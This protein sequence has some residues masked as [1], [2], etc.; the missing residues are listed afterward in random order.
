MKNDDI[1]E[2]ILCLIMIELRNC[3]IFGF[4]DGNKLVILSILCQFLRQ[5][6]L[7]KVLKYIR[8]EG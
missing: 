8:K 6:T 2:C 4:I 3:N 7:Q 1:K 5:N